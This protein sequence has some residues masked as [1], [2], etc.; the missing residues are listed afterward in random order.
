MPTKNPRL[1]FTVSD[2]LMQKIT[3][4]QFQNRLK[5]QTQAIVSLINRGLDALSDEPIGQIP[6]F[7]E[8]EIQLIAEYRDAAPMARDMARTTLQSYPA[9][10]KERR[11]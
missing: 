10:E 2:E 1:T 11:A 3:D 6:K 4:H 7:T 9:K 8:D 5:N